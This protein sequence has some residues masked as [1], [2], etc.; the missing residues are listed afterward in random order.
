MVPLLFG[1][2]EMAQNARAAASDYKI[3]PDDFLRITVF[4]KPDLTMGTRVQG[5]GTIAYWI[6]GAI[7]VSGK[8]AEQVKYVIKEKLAAEYLVDS[9]V[10]VGVL[11]YK[12][13]TFSVMG[14][15]KVPRVCT[16]PPGKEIDINRSYCRRGKIQ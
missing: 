8:T 5:N 10:H 1:G 14:S 15:V 11:I 16:I 2:T 13:Q 12:E 9:R 7:K 6:L 4:K 3:Q